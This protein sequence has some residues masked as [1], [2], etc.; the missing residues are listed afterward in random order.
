MLYRRF[1]KAVALR[2]ENRTKIVALGAVLVGLLL[3]LIFVSGED[4][5]QLRSKESIAQTQ[6]EGAAQED[7]LAEG[8]EA[9]AEGEG[10]EAVAEGEEAVAEGDEEVGEFAEAEAVAE[11]ELGGFLQHGTV[12][13]RDGAMQQRRDKWPG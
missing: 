12:G 9:V 1:L 10:E 7:E 2:P 5:Q 11:G 13:P 8:E 3:A 6:E 4:E